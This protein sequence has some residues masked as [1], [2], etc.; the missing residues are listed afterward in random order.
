MV[1]VSGLHG[2][3]VVTSPAPQQHEHVIV[4]EDTPASG[5]DCIE[6]PVAH[7]EEQRLSRLHQMAMRDREMTIRLNAI[8]HDV[9]VSLLPILFDYTG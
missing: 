9:R 3:A 2:P 7:S 6:V 4:V 5:G 1:E 8:C